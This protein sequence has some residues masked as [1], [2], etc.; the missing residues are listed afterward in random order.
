MERCECAGMEV[1]SRRCLSH[2]AQPRCGLFP[3]SFPLQFHV[4]LGMSI[5]SAAAEPSPPHLP[6]LRALSWSRERAE[7]RRALGSVPQLC[8]RQGMALSP[9]AFL[10][11]SLPCSAGQSLGQPLQSLQPSWQ[12]FPQSFLSWEVQVTATR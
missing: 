9:C 6:H 8:P 3:A 2:R 4:R 10:S 11:S 12:P 7:R 5:H 1:R